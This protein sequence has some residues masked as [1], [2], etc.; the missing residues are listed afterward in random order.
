MPVRRNAVGAGWRVGGACGGVASGV[1]A[2]GIRCLGAGIFDIFSP[3]TYVTLISCRVH[4]SPGTLWDNPLGMILS[5]G[6]V[7]LGR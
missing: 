6:P 5:S 2:E 3:E 4:H 1:V 7:A